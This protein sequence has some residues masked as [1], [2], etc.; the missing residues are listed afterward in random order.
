MPKYT[1]TKDERAELDEIA[2]AS[3]EE[4][5]MEV[6]DDYFYS[7]R[8]SD[9]TISYN[10]SVDKDGGRDWE[11]SLG[12]ADCEY[13]GY[14]Y[15]RLE[16]T[17]KLPGAF[18]A[19]LSVGCYSGDGVTDVRLSELAAF[20][21]DLAERYTGYGW[22]RA[23]KQMAA[24]IRS[25]ETDAR[26]GSGYK[27]VSNAAAAINAMLNGYLTKDQ[28]IAAAAAAGDPLIGRPSEDLHDDAAAPFTALEEA[29]RD[30]GEWWDALYD[31]IVEQTTGPHPV[32]PWVS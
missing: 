8:E 24:D 14:N 12:G 16:V 26:D 19:Q 10:S 18:D 17:E 11:L 25:S 31:D 1:P 29:F 5:L 9:D 3:E 32:A 27:K 30:G 22:G 20:V 7:P 2:Q 21:D 13:C 6:D 23:F 15:D 28:A 4:A